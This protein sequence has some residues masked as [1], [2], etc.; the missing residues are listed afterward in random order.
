MAIN[1][2]CLGL[3][4][5]TTRESGC[6]CYLVGVCCRLS[7]YWPNHSLDMDVTGTRAAFEALL[8]QK[9]I[10]KKLGLNKST[11]ST[12]KK[13]LENGE[14]VTL[15]KMEEILQLAGA[16]VVQEKVFRLPE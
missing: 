15:D 2:I 11:V 1:Q 4:P 14:G 16:V 7:Y 9:G 10:A 8:N 12:L 3:C 13:R 6:I 5:R